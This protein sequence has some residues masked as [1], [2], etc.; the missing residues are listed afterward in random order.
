MLPRLRQPYV[1]KALFCGLN[2]KVPCRFMCLNILFPVDG[3]VMEAC[4][5]F[6][7]ESFVESLGVA[8]TLLARLHSPSA[9]CSLTVDVV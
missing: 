1:T 6:M 4:R 7:L 3:D 8:L 5:T 2:V 9:L